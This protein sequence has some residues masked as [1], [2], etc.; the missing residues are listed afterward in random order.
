[1]KQVTIAVCLLFTLGCAGEHRA[2]VL[3]GQSGLA[4]AQAVGQLQD[5]TKALTG[6]TITPAQALVVQQ[7]LLAINDKIRPLSEM[8]RTI[9]RMEQAHE[10][11]ADLVN[12]TIAMLEVIGQDVSVS[13]FGVP[14]NETTAALIDTIR[15][16]QQTV[17]TTLVALGQLKGAK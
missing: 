15:A 12:Q 4:A 8:L 10:S 3:V 17:Q 16:A 2:A 6:P 11:S 1:M 9:D 7:R 13:L 14:L 5:T